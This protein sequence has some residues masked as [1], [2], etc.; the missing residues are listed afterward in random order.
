M[1]SVIAVYALCVNL[2]TGRDRILDG[3]IFSVAIVFL[4]KNVNYFSV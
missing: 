4:S 2:F 3:T 1:K